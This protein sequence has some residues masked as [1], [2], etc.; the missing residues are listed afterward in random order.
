MQFL[1]RF[2]LLVIHFVSYKTW[3]YAMGIKILKLIA[4]RMFGKILIEEQTESI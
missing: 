4:E 3:F 2:N 1:L